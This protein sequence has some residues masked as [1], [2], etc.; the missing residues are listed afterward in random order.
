MQLTPAM[1]KFIL[2]WGEMGMKWGVNR[3][4]AQIHALLILADRPLTAEEITETLTIARSNVSNSI[5]ELLSLKLVERVHIMG[6][7]KDH[8]VAEKE[9]W[10]MLMAISRAR[11]QREIDPTLSILTDCVAEGKADGQTPD[12][13]LKRLEHLLE[14]IQNMSTWYDQVHRL[15][16]STLM[17]LMKMGTKVANFVGGKPK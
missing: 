13:A 6:D 12:E 16:K 3:S 11:K 9:P 15:P 2:H 4:I 17:A 8:F 1:E 10:E 14:F 5:K 7:R